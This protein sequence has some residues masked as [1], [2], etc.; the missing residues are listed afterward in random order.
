MTRNEPLATLEHIEGAAEA[1]A[2][3]TDRV[4][5]FQVRR[6]VIDDDGNPV[7][8][9]S[10]PQEADVEDYPVLTE[11]VTYTMPA[12]PNPGFALKYL[13]LARQIG[14]AASSW[15]IETAVGEEGYDALA[16]DLVTYEERN[17]GQ[18]IKLLQRIA[19]RIQTVAMGGLDA[20]PKA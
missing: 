14:D 20:G 6:P 18:S 1:W 3:S 11:L 10:A 16:E 17:P 19:E 15:L 8:D 9:T 13:K 12:K 2:T 4:P 7:L 5:V